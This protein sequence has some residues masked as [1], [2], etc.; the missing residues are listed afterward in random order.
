MG[1][2]GPA[3]ERASIIS[4]QIQ[5]QVG[6]SSHM[7]EGFCASVRLAVYLRP[8][9]LCSSRSR[10]LLSRR[11]SSSSVRAASAFSTMGSWH[12][13]PGTTKEELSLEFTLP[14]GQS[15]RW[16]RVEA[17]EPTYDGVVGQRAVCPVEHAAVP[18]RLCELHH[19]GLRAH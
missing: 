8:G 17:A 12:A 14:T 6:A 13:I 9:L 16:R 4:S 15:F 19:V 2:T 5:E 1:V 18:S 10:A 7:L 11:A 3:Q